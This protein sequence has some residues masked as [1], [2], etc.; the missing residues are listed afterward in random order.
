[1]PFTDEDVELGQ[2][3]QSRE[4]RPPFEGRQNLSLSAC[5]HNPFGISEGVITNDVALCDVCNATR[6]RLRLSFPH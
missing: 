1:M 3:K 6:P 4:Y 2:E 5:C